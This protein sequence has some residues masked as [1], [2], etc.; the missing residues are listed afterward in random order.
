MGEF[1]SS[2]FLRM[3]GEYNWKFFRP[4]FI[5]RFIRSFQEE[6]ERFSH[7]QMTNAVFDIEESGM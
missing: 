4:F 6:F 7:H 5:G 3:N 1:L 2:L